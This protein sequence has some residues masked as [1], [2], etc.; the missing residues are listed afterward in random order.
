MSGQDSSRTT[1]PEIRS[2][3]AT[4]RKIAMLTACDAPTARM[5]DAAGAD[6]ILVG[7]SLAMI[8]LGHDTTLSITMDEMIH[9]A[10]AVTRARPRALV[11]G[12]MPYLSYHV[13]VEDSVRSAGRF[14]SEAGCGG[15]KVEGGRKRLRVIG[16][17]VDAEIPVMGHLGLTP[18]SFHVMG[19]FRV[20]AKT[21]EAAESLV[22]EARLLAEAGVFSIVLECVPS[23]VARVITAE[24]AVPT[25]GIGAGPGCDGQ[26]LV[27]HDIL[28]M[29]WGPTPRFVRRY[30]EF[31][32]SGRRALAS[33]V[34]DVT[35]GRFPSDA[36][37]YHLPPAAAERIRSR[38][39]AAPA[40]SP[41]PTRD[42]PGG[43]WTS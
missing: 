41:G 12:D 33:F 8:A 16:A 14:V 7:D 15:V 28:G 9:H 26:V 25:I 1:V 35:A 36:E 34:E 2:R 31:A 10:K 42:D 22:R 13:S 30:A 23:E 19:G 24:V 39:G 5:A 18:Q 37:S 4:G 20:Q 32:E 17:L 11:I 38:A 3:K 40:D 43:S 6:I 29:T 21:I 27:T